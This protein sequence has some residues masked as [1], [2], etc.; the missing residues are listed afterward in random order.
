VSPGGVGFYLFS[1]MLFRRRLLDLRKAHRQRD[2]AIISAFK[3]GDISRHSQPSARCIHR[4]EVKEEAEKPPRQMVI[5][6]NAAGG[7]ERRWV[8][9]VD[10]ELRKNLH[11]QN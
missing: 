6:L 1:V 4:S 2:L 9:R 10:G 7:H 5:P 11:E 8:R 3:Q